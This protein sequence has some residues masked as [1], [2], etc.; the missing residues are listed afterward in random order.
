LA[1][2]NGYAFSVTDG[3]IYD[4]GT[5]L[6]VDEQTIIVSKYSQSPNALAVGFSVEEEII[7]YNI[8]TTLL[9]NIISENESAPGADRLKLTPTLAV[10]TK[11]Q[12]ATNSEFLTLVEWNNG[13]PY[14]QNQTTQFSALGDAMAQQAFDQSGNFVMDAFQVATESTANAALDSSYFTMVVDPGQAYINGR[15]V[16]TLSN[17]KID[18]KKGLD[19][20]LANNT[21]SLNYGNYVRVNEVSGG[22]DTANAAQISLRS[23]PTQYISNSDQY[24]TGT[25]SAYGREIGTARVRAFIHESGSPGDANAIYRAY[26]FDVRLNAG[27]S[28]DG[29]RALY[30]DHASYDAV[31]DAVLEYSPQRQEF[32]AELKDTNKN[33]LLF[34]AGVSS[35][36]NSNTSTYIYRTTGIVNTIATSAQTAIDLSAGSEYLPYGTD[37][38]LSFS[39]LREIVMIPVFEDLQFTPNFTGTVDINTANGLVTG[40]GTN[41]YSDFEIGDY[42]Y[43]IDGGSEETRRIT[44]IMSATTLR[45]DAPF[46]S[47]NATANF[48]RVFPKN[49]PMPYGYREGLTANVDVT[50]QILTLDVAHSNGLAVAFTLAG[51]SANS[52]V[53]YNVERRNT[54]SSLKTANR[55]KYVKISVANNADGIDGPWCLGVPDAFRLR[56]VYHHTDSTVNTNSADVTDNFYI[57]HNQTANFLNH[58]FLYRIGTGSFTTT[59]N[60]WF[61]VCFDYFTNDDTGYYDAR[62]YRRTS[63]AADIATS[64]ARSFNEMS[65][66]NNAAAAISWEIPEVYTSHDKYFDLINQFDF[67]PPVDATATPNSNAASAPVNPAQ[68]VAFTGLQKFPTPD[69]FMTTQVEHYVGRVDDVY[70]GETGNIFILKGISD[71]NP[72]RRL[73]SNHPKDSLRLQMLNIPPYPNYIQNQGHYGRERMTT[74]TSNEKLLGLR[75]KVR[76]IAPIINTRNLQTSQPMVY[77]MEDIGNLERRIADLEYY[78]SLSVLET[79]MSNKVIPS[80]ID[81]TLNRF[82]YGFFADDYSTDVYSDIANPQYAASI[83]AEGDMFFGSALNPLQP[84][85]ANPDNADDPTNRSSATPISIVQN[86]TNRAV[87]LKHIWG[88]RHITDN[89]LF[90]D[91]EIMSQLNTTDRRLDGTV[92]RSDSC[93]ELLG[94]GTIA[95]NS[96]LTTVNKYRSSFYP[97]GITGTI[98]VYFDFINDNIAYDYGALMNIYDPSGAIIATTNASA[99]TVETLT[100]NDK[101]FL[102]TD[103]G[104]ERFYT[105]ISQS[106]TS[107]TF[108]RSGLEADYGKG[109][110]KLTFTSLTSGE[111]IIETVSTFTGTMYKQLAVWPSLLAA[112]SSVINEATCKVSEPAYIGTLAAGSLTLK[113][114]SCSNWFRIND[115]NYRAFVLNAYGLKPNTIHSLYLDT[116]TWPFAVSIDKDD[117]KAAY[118]DNK[119]AATRIKYTG[120]N[121]VLI[122]SKTRKINELQ[123]FLQQARNRM[124]D[125]NGNFLQDS[126]L[127]TDNQGKIRC[128][129]FFP[130]DLAGW[131]SQDFNASA[132]QQQA[133]YS[134]S[135]WG[136]YRSYSSGSQYEAD[137]FVSKLK[138]TGGSSGYSAISLKDSTGESVAERIFANRTPFK[139]IPYDPKGNI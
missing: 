63:V 45:V 139:V 43:T 75:R 73:Q 97:E 66:G 19:T 115:T 18:L 69:G 24:S 48:T 84:K 114:W 102:S 96:Y 3:Y 14:K 44:N 130:L 87:P 60:S 35:L 127:T 113:Q 125:E 106:N 138:P 59:S 32:V 136:K 100:D 133:T 116:E 137:N 27:E 7:D 22:F 121:E 94:D 15:K 26:L 129:V 71:I 82:K 28:F 49:I 40:A 108:V 17:Y 89:P 11:E 90:I 56:A 101:V 9:D 81:R 135:G 62:S 122:F 119:S 31:A 65:T 42:I 20:K 61:L 2:G 47:A 37:R 110:G 107:N 67:R 57:D 12:A 91:E 21:I 53:S 52:R 76:T 118:L 16:Q 92:N 39:E 25:A 33:Q 68:T 98:T 85:V 104:A 77:T 5:F 111:H 128:L 6:K 13:K 131:F 8:D 95:A 64:D 58:S 1:I 38:E 132:Y 46:S 41:F 72:R 99:N 124:Q 74:R 80:S 30:Y 29:V 51:A 134:T 86:E 54:Q 34:S 55:G 93:V 4:V 78:V 10:Q 88:I 105:A 123:R 109:I 70:I 83:E 103:E 117:F 120:T 23:Q 50:G 112:G 126:I 79:T 36:K